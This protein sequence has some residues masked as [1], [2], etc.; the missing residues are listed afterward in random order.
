M[1]A[2]SITKPL[3]VLGLMHSS[4]AI[5]GRDS[6][7]RVL[8]AS[9]LWIIAYARFSTGGQDLDQQRTALKA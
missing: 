9:G 5:R 4:I 2:T 8:S 1:I 3:K 6:I 7:W